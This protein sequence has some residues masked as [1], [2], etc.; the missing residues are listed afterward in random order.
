MYVTLQG[1]PP[2]YTNYNEETAVEVLRTAFLAF[3]STLAKYR[4]QSVSVR[5]GDQ[6]VEEVNAPER[7]KARLLELPQ[8]RA[9]AA[10]VASELDLYLLEDG[11]TFEECPLSWWK[12]RKFRFPV[13]YEMAEFI[14]LYRLLVRHPSV[15]FQLV[16]WC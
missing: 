5:H 2:C 3:P 14:L 13:L 7:K 16:V 10:S 8:K 6:Q 9:V 4:G 11:I 1:L 12:G 15:C